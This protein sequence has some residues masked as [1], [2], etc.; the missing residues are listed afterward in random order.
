[1]ATCYV[2]AFNR[3]RDFYQVPLALE[4]EGKL[5]YLITD[6][7]EAKWK[8]G[9]HLMGRLG[10]GHRRCAGLSPDRVIWCWRAIWLQMFALKGARSAVER[11]K[12]FRAIDIAISEVAGTVAQQ[13]GADLFLYSG[14]AREAFLRLQASNRLKLLFVYHPQGD[15]V[16]AI[17]EADAAAHPEAG[18]S[19]QAHLEEIR[20]NEGERVRQELEM[21]DAVACASSFTAASVK[22][23]PGCT[24][25]LVHVVPYGCPPPA[26][27]CA[28]AAAPDSA[29]P[30]FLFV[31]QGV[32]R[33]GLHHL[34][35][36]WRAGSLGT[37]AEL[38]LVL[39]SLD[40]GIGRLAAALPTPPRI[41]SRLTKA[42]L[43]AEYRRADI[44]VLPSLVEGFG[45]VYLE[46]LSAGCLVVG[47]TN[48]GLPDLGLGHEA[49]R[50][51]QPGDIQG[52]AELLLEAAKE[53]GDKRV[54]RQLI[55]TL[56]AE[57][58]WS[59]FRDGIRRF[60]QEAESQTTAPSK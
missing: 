51:S 59:R 18:V 12:V 1:M 4:E 5:A 54:D 15:Y 8:L 17:L 20:I 11:N 22:A 53:V 13:S 32:Q 7:Y 46:A 25:K 42:E 27:V 58:S 60:V 33:K 41:L 34:I 3:D 28:S 26:D 19:H 24:N 38:T 44:F 35:K 43:E 45:L 48:T 52:L 47:T 37:V 2:T 10:L 57:L 31:G 30:Q 50:F 14:Y 16:R 21:A 9:R 55:K 40:P 39:S 49:V 56:A 29:R 36:A 23:C 6:L